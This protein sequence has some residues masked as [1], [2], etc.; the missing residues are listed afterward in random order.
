MPVPRAVAKFERHIAVPDGTQL[1][2]QSVNMPAHQVQCLWT[3]GH[4]RQQ[5]TLSLGVQRHFHMPQLFRGK[6]HF[7]RIISG[8]AQELND[9]AFDGQVAASD[10]PFIRGADLRHGQVSTCLRNLA[11]R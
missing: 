1:L 5:N 11:K 10:S 8:I 4:D 2:R 9:L 7:Y 6:C 3:L